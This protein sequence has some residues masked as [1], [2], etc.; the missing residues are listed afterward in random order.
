MGGCSTGC[1]HYANGEV[2]HIK[3]CLYYIGSLS[4]EFDKLQAKVDMLTRII[5]AENERRRDN[6]TN[7]FQMN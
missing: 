5:E 1:K 2:K 7:P 4:E 6:S 3:E